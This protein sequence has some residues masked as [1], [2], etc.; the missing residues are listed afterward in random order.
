LTVI[1][2]YGMGNLRSVEK[3]VQFLGYR[4]SVQPNLDGASKLIIPGVGAFGAAMERIG[5][6]RDDLRAFAAEGKPLL[7]ICLG[8]QLLFDCSEEMGDH[9]GLGLIR[10]S[11]KY[12]PSTLG[13]KVP[14]I[15]WSALDVTQEDGIAAGVERG[16]QV[17]FVHSLYTECEDKADVAAVTTYG[18]EFPSAVQRGNVWGTQF[19]PEKSGAVGLKILQ[20]FLAC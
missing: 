10:G 9:E 7:G 13:L 14:H 11:V 2:D 19:H 4:C 1:L 6:L 8:Q 17:Y 16:E 15:G 5:P 20:N 3:A 18:I 12:L